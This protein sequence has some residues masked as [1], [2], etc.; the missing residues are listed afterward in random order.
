VPIR[1]AGTL[2]AIFFL[3]AASLQLNDP[4]PIQWIAIYLAAAAVSALTVLGKGSPAIPTIVGAIAL[5]WGLT[6]LPDAIAARFSLDDEEVRELGGLAIVATWC[7]IS[8]A[9]RRFS[10]A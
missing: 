4:D 8:G 1:V 6:L 9:A 7:A 3:W 2:F 10:R 5:V